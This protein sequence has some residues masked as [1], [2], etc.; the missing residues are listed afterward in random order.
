M[1]FSSPDLFRYLSALKFTFMIWEK[2]EFQFSIL[3]LL[4]FVWG[5]SAK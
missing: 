1:P 3:L 5:S 2:R 4:A